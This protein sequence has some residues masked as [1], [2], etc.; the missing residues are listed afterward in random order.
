[1]N[2][3]Q[4]NEMIENYWANQPA[5]MMTRTAIR[6]EPEYNGGIWGIIRRWI[7]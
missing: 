7:Q 5:R 1:M 3:Q 4:R 6:S 2:I